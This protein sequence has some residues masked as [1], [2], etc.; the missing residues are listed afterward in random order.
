[1][2]K[3][4]KALSGI[5]YPMWTIMH[6]AEYALPVRVFQFVSS[7]AILWV[8]QSCARLDSFRHVGILLPDPAFLARR[9]PQISFA[10]RLLRRVTGSTS[11][12]CYAIKSSSRTGWCD[13]VGRLRREIGGEVFVE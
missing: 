8:R 13:G 10:S 2:D 3:R 7:L 11:R 5:A 6:D 12:H 4:G 9:Q 1:M